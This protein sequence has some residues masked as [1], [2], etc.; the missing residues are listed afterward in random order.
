MRPPSAGLLQNLNDRS[1]GQGSRGGATAS[2]GGAASGPGK[3]KKGGTQAK[4]GAGAAADVC[5]A[6][7]SCSSD[8]DGGDFQAPAGSAQPAKRRKSAEVSAASKA[9]AAG[10]PAPGWPPPA[11]AGASAAATPLKEQLDLGPWAVSRTSCHCGPACAG[12]ACIASCI[13]HHAH[14]LWCLCCA[15]GVRLLHAAGIR[16][17]PG[18]D[19]KGDLVQHRPAAGGRQR[20][21]VLL[22][23]AA[24]HQGAEARR[25]GRRGGQHRQEA[26]R[27]RQGQGHP[28]CSR[29]CGSRG[30]QPWGSGWPRQRQWHRGGPV[31][32]PH[33]PAAGPGRPSALTL[34]ARHA[35]DSWAV[36]R[37]FH[38]QRHCSPGAAHGGAAACRRA[39]HDLLGHA[40]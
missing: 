22:H 8:S 13:A 3:G 18:G 40:G 14:G 26:A 17:P 20:L 30:S 25:S 27:Q 35:S 37:H 31:P 15:G 24:A 6:D 34:H 1:L 12:A 39:N 2:K 4:L 10:K 9:P 11:A 21:A 33:P 36:R 32:A 16:P 38:H 19:A 29:G 7:V 23:P 28:R 5:A